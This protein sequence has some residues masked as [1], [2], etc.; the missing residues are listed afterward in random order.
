MSEA[1][2][3]IKMIRRA[4]QA[5]VAILII[6]FTLT[7]FADLVVAVNIGVILATLHFLKRMAASVDVRQSTE[8]ELLQEFAHKGFFST[9]KGCIS[10]YCRGTV[11][12]RR[13]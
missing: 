8:V 1:K 2:H 7:V 3:V 5:D 13:G 9:A 12:F 11:F 4:P 10:V 6:T